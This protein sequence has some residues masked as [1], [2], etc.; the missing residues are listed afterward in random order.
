M[1]ARLGILLGLWCGVALAQTE[2]LT[3]TVTNSVDATPIA[4]ARVTLSGGGN[5]YQTVLTDAGGRFVFGGVPHGNYSLMADRAGYLAP[6]QGPRGVPAI[7][8]VAVQGKPD[9]VAMQL[10]PGATLT[11]SVTDEAGLPIP[12]PEVELIHRVV[13]NGRGRLVVYAGQMVGNDLGEFRMSG[14]AADRYLVCVNAN[15]SSYQRHRRLTYPTTCFPGVTDPSSAQWVN[16]G[17][18]EERKLAFHITP[19]S[20]IRVSGSAA[21]AG[22]GTSVSI[23][24]T[25]PPG[26]P[27]LF[28]QPV[29]WNEKT[30]SF[31][32]LAVSP[33]DYLITANQFGADGQ[34]PRAMRSIRVGTE[35]I[36]DIKLTLRDGPYLSGTVQMGDTPASG[37]VRVSVGFDGDRGLSIYANAGGSF[38]QAITEP[39]N[40][41]VAVFPPPGWSLQAITQGGVDIRERKIA[42]GADDDPEPIEILLGRGGG[43]IEITAQN[44]L[45]KGITPVKL[46]LLRPLSTENEWA[47]QGQPMVVNRE[48][49]LS[50]RNIPSG[51]YLLFACPTAMEIEYLNPE[52][53]EKYRSFGQAVSVREGDTT[54]VTVL[55]IPIE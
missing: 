1:T 30:A 27:Q 35:D 37:Q 13:S 18:G 32:I 16:L 9:P 40:Y 5:A 12:S 8:N 43:T 6:G 2:S 38:K 49:A 17:P 34:N 20:G 24:R 11:G 45:A 52:V 55:P 31:E 19:V 39:G 21:N 48:G 28:S 4:G 36:R 7:V 33:G 41:S 14:L 47:P 50:L 44:A 26:F 25:D 42:I 23:R 3:G 29:V 46:I 22:K 15:A 53:I 54:R 51:E 10:T